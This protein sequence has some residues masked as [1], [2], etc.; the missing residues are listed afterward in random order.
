MSQLNP[1]DRLPCPTCKCDDTLQAV[2]K[3]IGRMEHEIKVSRMSVSD[4]TE[5]IQKCEP[6]FGTRQDVHEELLRRKPGSAHYQSVPGGA[7]ERH[8]G[9]YWE[10]CGRCGTFYD[11][12]A[13]QTLA[14]FKRSR[15]RYN[16]ALGKV[17]DA[18]GGLVDDD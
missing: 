14:E 2:G 13:H 3:D 17:I 5:M 6:K 10:T 4:A 1:S 18:L 15:Q 8:M 16:L 7:Q 11:P 12:Y 9:F